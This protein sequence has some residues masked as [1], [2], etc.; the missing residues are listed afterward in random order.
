[1]AP[2][3]GSAEQREAGS[4]LAQAAVGRQAPDNELTHRDCT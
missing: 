3:E 4:I 2:R 1:M